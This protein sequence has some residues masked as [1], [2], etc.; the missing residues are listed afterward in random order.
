MR[1][2]V[3]EGPFQ[4]WGLDFIGPINPAFSAGH[5]YIMTTTDYFTKWVEAKA[6]KKTTSEVVCE[7]IKENILVR[8]GVPIKLVMDN[9]S[10]FSSIEITDFY[11][12]YG[13]HVSH[14]SDY[15]PQGN[16]QAESSNKNL[17]NIVKKPVSDS[18][19]NWHK[20]I[21]EAL[22]AD[23]V[24]PKREIGVSPFKLVYG[25]EASLPLPL[26]LA[27]SKLRT[28]IED[29]IYKDGLEKR[30]LYLSKLEEERVEIDDHIT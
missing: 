13:I 27:T 10:Y 19:K 26:E 16:G 29:D 11:F 9:A 12:E 23:R 3:I 30:M 14:S 28:V 5:Q 22:W 7:F 21:H 1:P 25:M 4:Q 2:V 20:K 8:F 6:M 17:I 15:F 24:T 18:Q